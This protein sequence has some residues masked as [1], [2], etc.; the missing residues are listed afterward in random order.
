MMTTPVMWIV[1][2]ELCTALNIRLHAYCFMTNHYHLL[3]LSRVAA[4]LPALMQQLG[5]CYV[6]R[7]NRLYRRSCTLGGRR[8]KSSLV[9]KDGYLLAC[10]RYIELN[11]EGASMVVYPAEYC[12]SSY[13]NNSPRAVGNRKQNY[14]VSFCLETRQQPYRES[15]QYDLAQG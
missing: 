7:I 14:E 6:Q 9:V 8:F 5:Q 11:T 10:Y 15:L 12:W 1:L 13:L 4:T 2:H 3:V